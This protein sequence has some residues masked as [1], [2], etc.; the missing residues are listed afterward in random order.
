MPVIDRGHPPSTIVFGS[1]SSWRPSETALGLAISDLCKRLPHSLF[2]KKE[3]FL[4]WSSIVSSFLL[5]KFFV[6]Q[7]E[8]EQLLSTVEPQSRQT[9]SLISS[10]LSERFFFFGGGSS[11]AASSFFS[12]DD[13]D[14]FCGSSASDGYLERCDSVLRAERWRK[15]L[16]LST[17]LA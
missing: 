10:E 6:R 11:L 12:S 7:L 5:W 1:S 16:I 4:F 15:T 2:K 13:L 3:F 14:S 17:T 9:G 8:E